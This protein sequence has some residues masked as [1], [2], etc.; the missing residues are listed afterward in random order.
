MSQIIFY[1]GPSFYLRQKKTGNIL[2]S[3]V[4]ILNGINILLILYNIIIGIEY[5]SGFDI[6]GL[7]FHK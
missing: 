2:F 7:F 3:V 6:Y 4:S 1:I 5:T